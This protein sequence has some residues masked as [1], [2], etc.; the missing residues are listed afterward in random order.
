MPSRGKK[1]VDLHLTLD[2]G[3]HLARQLYRRIRDAVVEGRL[4]AGDMLP[5]SRELAGRLDVSRNTVVLVYERLRAEGFLE[6]RMGSGTYVHPDVR[7]EAP[8]PPAGSPLRSREL[9]SGIPEP[10]DLS[11]VRVRYDFRPGMPDARRF[12]YAAWRARTAR[13]LRRDRIGTGAHIGPAGLPALRAAVARHIG[14]SRGVRASEDDVFITNGSQQAIG[15]IA[16]V[17]LEPGDVVAVEDPGYPLTRWAYRAHGCRVVGVPV[18]SEGLIVDAIPEETRLVYVT[19]SHQYPLG[20]AMSLRRRQALLER[21]RTAGLAVVE[22]D[23]DSE[24]RYGGRPL[25]PLR[26]LDRTGRVLYLGSFSKTLLPTL[27]LGF[28]VVPAPLHG[29]FARA[30]ATTD[31]HTPV[32]LQGTAAE[33][34]D[35]GLLAQHVRRMRRIYAERHARIMSVLARD[36]A[37]DLETVPSAGGLHVSAFLRGGHPTRDREVVTAAR[38]HDVAV[39]ALSRHFHDVPAR[40]GLLIGYGAI[41]VDRIKEGLHRVRALL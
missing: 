28:A 9:W 39:F 14:V 32:P 1:P 23:Y 25:E 13:Q 35:D 30:K 37:E 4:L 15:L 12:P 5:S 24:F 10:V 8:V 22:D 7:P 6:S 38:E 16:R 34:I 41:P 31:W 3:R 36:F 26:T 40:G 2:G 19:P 20:V 21:A 11:A 17:L 33:F 29:A 18:D 27:R